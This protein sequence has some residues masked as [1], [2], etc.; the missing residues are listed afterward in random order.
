[1]TNHC[2]GRP[3]K[4][5]GPSVNSQENSENEIS[6]VFKTSKFGNS[7]EAMATVAFRVVSF[8]YDDGF[9]GDIVAFV[10]VTSALDDLFVAIVEF[11]VIASASYD[12]FNGGN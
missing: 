10:T 6:V 3:A 11:C 1:M 7:T 4:I 5:M 8:V 12:G 9:N 2:I